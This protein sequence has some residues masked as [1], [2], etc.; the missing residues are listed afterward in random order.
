MESDRK[1]VPPVKG[2][3]KEKK[4][5]TIMIMRSV[6]KIRSFKISLRILLITAIFLF[7]YILTSLYILNDYF[8]IRSKH[9]ALTKK[10]DTLEENLRSYQEELH[11]TNLYVAS[12]EDYLKNNKERPAKS[13]GDE[14]QDIDQPASDKPAQRVDTETT[15]EKNIL[16]MVE[17][18][19]LEFNKSD[20]NLILDF[21]LANGKSEGDAAEGYIHII[22]MDANKECPQTWNNT[23]DRLTECTPVNYRLG[24]QFLIQRFRAYNKTFNPDSESELPSFIKILAYDRSG[25]ILI[26]KEFPVINVS[27]AENM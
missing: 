9:K 23:R 10:M 16:N 20:E 5:F 1:I 13:D 14:K 17:I 26:E 4:E 27:T 11:D 24:Q 19:D 8:N 25:H 21:K 18:W 7:L 6:G 2:G 3:K 22:A 15:A 12:L